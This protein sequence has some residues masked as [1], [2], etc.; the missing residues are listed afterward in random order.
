MTNLFQYLFNAE[1]LKKTHRKRR[2]TNSR[3]QKPGRKGCRYWLQLAPRAPRYSRCTPPFPSFPHLLSSQVLCKPCQ[4]LPHPSITKH[5]RAL[6]CQE[7][8]AGVNK[9][10]QTTDTTH[11]FY[12]PLGVTEKGY[13]GGL[14][15]LRARLLPTV[16]LP[17]SLLGMLAGMI[18]RTDPTYT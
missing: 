16:G 12:Q 1:W 15:S 3:S 14:A 7:L 8:I 6:P 11:T 13:R 10:P 18:V 4:A 2:K 17:M 5:R 9:L